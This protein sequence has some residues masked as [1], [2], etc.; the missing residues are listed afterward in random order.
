MFIIFIVTLL[1]VVIL[2]LL[3]ILDTHRIAGKFILQYSEYFLGIAGRDVFWIVMVLV[4]YGIIFC[5]FFVPFF[6]AA[7]LEEVA[8]GRLLLFL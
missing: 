6:I 2:V 8:F 5:G 4:S 1:P 3:P 7:Q